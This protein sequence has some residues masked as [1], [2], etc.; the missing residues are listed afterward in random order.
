M[1]HVQTS[2]LFAGAILIFTGAISVSR[3]INA[4]ERPATGATASGAPAASDGAL[5]VEFV[6]VLRH[7]RCMN[8]HSR[9][10]FPRQGDDGHP[11]THHER[12]SWS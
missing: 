6:S 9:G 1:K 7:P 12:A 3:P 4:A 10:D 11:H 8:C 2:V 5:F